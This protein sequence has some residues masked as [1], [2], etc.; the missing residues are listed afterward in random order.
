MIYLEKAAC[1]REIQED[2]DAQK[3]KPEWNTIPEVPDSEQAKRLR[4][5]FFDQL[6][7]DRL[8]EALVKE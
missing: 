2:F 3:A 8:R 4:E 7:K 5:N 6:N 1:P